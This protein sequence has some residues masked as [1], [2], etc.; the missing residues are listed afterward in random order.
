MEA[1]NE[2]SVPEFLRILE[3][4]WKGIAPWGETAQKRRSIRAANSEKLSEAGIKGVKY[5]DGFSRR[6]KEGS[7]NYVIFDPRVIE[8]S[9]IRGISIPFAAALLAKQDDDDSDL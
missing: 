6:K 2:L 4:T 9:K 7:R 8:I 3:G 5:Y 1:F